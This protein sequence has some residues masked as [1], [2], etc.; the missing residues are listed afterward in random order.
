MGKKGHARSGGKGKVPAKDVIS[1][2]TPCKLS[3]QKRNELNQII[4]KLLKVSSNFQTV[5]NAT[6]EW[7]R[8]LEIRKLL[9]LLDQIEEG[10][11]VTVEAEGARALKLEALLEWMQ[12]HGAEV[13]AVR[14]AHFQGFG[15]GLRAERDMGDGELVVAVPRRLMLTSE[16]VESSVLGSLLLKDPMLQHM[17]HVALALLLLVEKHSP[18]SFW[19]PYVLALPSSYSTVLYF[20]TQELQELKGSPA[21]EPALKHCRN[22][23]RQYAYFSKLFQNTSDPASDLLRDVFTYDEYRWAVS[24]VMTRH[25]QIPSRD[26]VA[27]AAGEDGGGG[28]GG[29]NGG[30]LVSALI[31]LWDLGN[32]SD[33]GLLTE[34]V[35]GRERS[36]CR[37]GAGQALAAGQQVLLR[38]GARPSADLLLHGGWVPAPGR[39]PHD[40]LPL[41]LGLARADPLRVDRQRLLAA[42][43]V[44][45]GPQPAD[46]AAGAGGS[47][48][49]PTELCLRQ[50]NSAE[51]AD[52]DPV[53]P[54]LR[55]FLRVFAM[56]REHLER[57]LSSPR[58]QDLLH[59]DCALDTEVE[60]RA[61]AFLLARTRL[62][63]A[64]YPTSLQ[65][66]LS[67]LE[68][69]SL[70]PCARLA[71]LLRASE[72]QLLEAA[73]D[74]AAPRV[75]P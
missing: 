7:E 2:G 47:G 14:P 62:L 64:A 26:A 38:Y 25:N 74:Y 45:A 12:E 58:V 37:V 9:E 28:G 29:G 46:V 35:V 24:T 36:E 11:K 68:S 3:R 19:R 17:P 56:K 70:S 4:D 43:G 6:K 21:F 54:P 61:W 16:H 33:D 50:P 51:G 69:G 32:H 59:P 67:L 39:N 15:W 75:H 55:A 71:V 31:P 8:H 1:S 13:G 20:S 42:L 18:Q 48:V 10:M 63:L 60:A 52:G 5:P 27:A 72:K 41:A 53:D 49:Q 22:I 44:N 57:W 30:N 34:F 73:R 23:A 66:D 65:E 40:R